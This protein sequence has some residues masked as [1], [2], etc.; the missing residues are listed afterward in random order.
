MQC[1]VLNQGSHFEVRLISQ[2]YVWSVCIVVCLGYS[3]TAFLAM[4]DLVMLLSV[5]SL[6]VV[7]CIFASIVIL[8]YGHLAARVLWS[9]YCLSVLVQFRHFLVA[10]VQSV[11]L[12]PVSA[13]SEQII[14]F[15]VQSFVA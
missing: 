4:S 10:L 5:V 7:L 1:G 12:C 3:R 2:G 11:H 14:V 15:P 8:R 9:V 13:H 6:S